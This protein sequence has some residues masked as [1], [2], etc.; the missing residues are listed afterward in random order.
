MI[1]KVAANVSMIQVKVGVVIEGGQRRGRAS[2]ILMMRTT[3]LRMQMKRTRLLLLLIVLHLMMMRMKEE[4]ICLRL[5]RLLIELNG[6]L[7]E[8]AGRRLLMHQAPLMILIARVV[9]ATGQL[10]R[11]L[12]LA[13]YRVLVVVLVLFLD[14]AAVSEQ[15]T[16]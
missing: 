13:T 14:G 8:V 10:M 5:K 6:L 9:G 1:P 2:L 3:K 15:L 12:V 7:I 11:E 16:R 4:I